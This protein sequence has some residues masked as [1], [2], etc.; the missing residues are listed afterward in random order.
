MPQPVFFVCYGVPRI[1]F[2]LLF[3]IPRSFHFFSS[4]FSLNERQG[5]FS[6]WN[7][8][9]Q[10]VLE[11]DSCFYLGSLKCFTF[12]EIWLWYL[13]DEQQKQKY[14]AS[15]S[16]AC[17]GKRLSNEYDQ[18]GKR[19]FLTFI[20]IRFTHLSCFMNFNIIHCI[21]HDTSSTLESSSHQGVNKYKNVSNTWQSLWNYTTR[22]SSHWT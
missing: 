22:H 16:I 5:T 19:V 1:F 8:S 10:N 2:K 12:L 14:L 21:R 15:F 4:C 9:H 7:K 6:T 3:C 13:V 18:I 11:F 20:I 17:I